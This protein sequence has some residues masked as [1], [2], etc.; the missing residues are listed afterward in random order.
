MSVE[1]SV[2][3]TEDLR[4][5]EEIDVDGGCDENLEISISKFSQ[6]IRLER[7]YLPA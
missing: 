3:E 2:R 6:R 7:S 5:A 4:L 1:L